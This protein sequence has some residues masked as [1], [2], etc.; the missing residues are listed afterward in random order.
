MKK[1]IPIIVSIIFL[2]TTGFSQTL[3]EYF[4]IAAENNPGL[5]AVFNE[6]QAALQKVPQVSTLPD[7]QFSFGYFLSSAETR[8]GPQL[9]KLSISQ[10]F[11]WFG[12]LEAQGNAA[13][14]SAKAKFQN[15]IDQRNKL[16][17]RVANAYYPIYELKSFIRIEKENIRILESYKTIA[18]Q[19]F[20]NGSGTMVDVLRADIMLEEART[21]LRILEDKERPLVVTFNK[22]LDRP[23]NTEVI[24]KETITPATLAENV[25]ARSLI[26]SNPKVKGLDYKLQASKTTE[27]AARKQSLPSV[28]IGL[29]YIIVGKRDD[30][31]LPDN[32][33]DVVAPMISVSL[34]IFRKKYTASVREA[35]LMQESYANQIEDETNRL[36]SEYET[37]LFEVQQQAQLLSLYEQQIQTTRQAL[38]LLSTS[39]GNSGKEFEELLRTLQQLLKYRKMSTS[40][41]ARH[42][43]ALQKINYLTSKKYSHEN[44]R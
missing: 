21:E 36:V 30:I 9:V 25:D 8:V 15:F 28:G 6:Y 33:K 40:A 12:T 18:N 35:Q 2:S 34:P 13:S 27:L 31:S 29:D 41:L 7:P 26:E 42:H 10:M 19:K 1:H 39:Y 38:D 20:E 14:L 22:L 16:Y 5:H 3:E 23:D 11:P 43:I 4:R 37:A 17:L 24:I 32:G 44:N